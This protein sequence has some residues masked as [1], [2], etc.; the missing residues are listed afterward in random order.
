MRRTDTHPVAIALFS[1]LIDNDSSIARTVAALRRQAEGLAAGDR[2]PSSRELMA[3]LGVGPVT[4]RRAVA[5]LVSEGLLV[6]RPGAGTFKAQPPRAQALDTTWQQVALGASPVQPAGLD[7]IVRR[8]E[9]TG[10]QLSSGYGDAAIRADSRIAAG[11]AR[12]ARRP[13]AWDYPPVR[14]LAELRSW[15]AG[16]IGV[17]RDEIF[18]SPGSQGALSSTIRALVPSGSPVLFAVPTYPGALAIARSAGLVPVPVPTD[19]DGVLPD[20]LERALAVTGSRLVYLQPTFSNPDGH[21]LTRQRRAAVL[22]VVASAG[23]FII[24]DDW[25]RWL[26]HGPPPPPPL[27]RDDTGGHVVTI[28]S[29]TKVAAPSLRVGAIAARGPVL[30]RIAAMRLVDDFFVA[31]PLQEAALDLVTG[32]GWHPHLRHLSATLRR[33]MEA[34]RLALAQQLPECSF[35]PPSGGNCLWLELPHGLSDDVVAERA[36]ALGVNVGAGRAYT[37]GEPDRAH[38]RLSV[39]A[40]DSPQIGEA[41]ALLAQAVRAPRSPE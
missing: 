27:I 2:L 16:E 31:R 17:S 13:G 14:G 10:L 15:F 26:G 20:L 12:A 40:I 22:E 18:I 28:A 38:L 33:R 39:S 35:D 7:L 25:A 6:T 3:R 30:E 19:R 21:F 41:V 24:E 4:V 37:I 34:L 9:A 23:A 5:N 1:F 11:I 29:L 8:R 36:A 32:P